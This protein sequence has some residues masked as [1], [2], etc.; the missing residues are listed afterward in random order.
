MI[1]TDLE[2]V[3]REMDESIKLQLHHSICFCLFL[4][5]TNMNGLPVEPPYPEEILCPEEGAAVTAAGVTVWH[6]L[7]KVRSVTLGFLLKCFIL[8]GFSR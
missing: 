1:E 8:I 6:I 5:I 7:S 2:K 4:F 3:L